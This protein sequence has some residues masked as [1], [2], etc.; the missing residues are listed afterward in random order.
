MKKDWEVMA[1]TGKMSSLKEQNPVVALRCVNLPKPN[2]P[3]C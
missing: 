3:L 1:A 2:A